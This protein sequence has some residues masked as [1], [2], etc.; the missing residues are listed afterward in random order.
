MKLRVKLFGS[1]A[2]Q[3][4][5]READLEVGEPATGADVLDAL[6]AAHPDAAG[7]RESLS[8][9]V[10]LEVVDV[11]TPVHDADEVALLPPTA[12]GAPILVGLREVPSTDEALAAVRAPGAGGTALFLGTVRDRS[13]AGEVTRLDYSAYE[14][15]ADRVMHDIAAEA[16]D[17][18]GLEA[19]CVLHGVG[20]LEVGAPTI[21]VAAAAPHRAEAFDACRYIVDEVKVRIPVW[22]EEHG[23]WGRRWV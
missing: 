18:W 22:K 4:G 11:S 21:V 8:V 19:V 15:M 2:E 14:A 7:L 9:A 3:V 1:L 13:E 12:G 23:E 10:N 5:T 6:F 16:M 17:K 20:E